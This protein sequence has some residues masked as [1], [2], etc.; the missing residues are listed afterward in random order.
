MAPEARAPGPSVVGCAAAAG[1]GSNALIDARFLREPMALPAAQLGAARYLRY[2]L[3]LA[4]IPSLAAA[5]RRFVARLVH[6][7]PAR[8]AK[9]LD[10]LIAWHATCSDDAAAWPGRAT[11]EAE[12]DA[13]AAGGG[14]PG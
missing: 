1:D 9:S 10:D 4:A 2:R 11:Q 5:R 6:D 3:A 8:W 13:A 7:D 12:V 14:P